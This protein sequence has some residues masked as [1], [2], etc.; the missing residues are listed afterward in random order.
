[1]AGFDG[2][3]VNREG[4]VEPAERLSAFLDGSNG[5]EDDEVVA[6]EA[7]ASVLVGKEVFARRE[8]TAVAAPDL[9]HEWRNDAIMH[10]AGENK[11]KFGK[12][13]SNGFMSKIDGGVNKQNLGLVFGEFFGFYEV[14]LLGENFY[15]LAAGISDSTALFID[16]IKVAV[17]WWEGEAADV[18]FFVFVDLII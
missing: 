11:I 14:E 16:V 7:G 18:E 6:V 12:T 15:I 5:A 3:V 2:D 8:D 10:V 4:A 9:V 1:M 13:R 17:I